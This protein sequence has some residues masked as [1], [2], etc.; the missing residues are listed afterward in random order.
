MYL[1]MCMCV[2]CCMIC[3][4]GHGMTW[5][6]MGFCKRTTFL[7]VLSCVLLFFYFKRDDTLGP[8]YIICELFFNLVFNHGLI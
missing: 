2:S 1:Y 7:A 8:I 6:G 5:H 4:Y 3:G